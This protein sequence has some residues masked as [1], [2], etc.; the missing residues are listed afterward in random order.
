MISV[1][2]AHMRLQPRP[3]PDLNMLRVAHEQSRGEQRCVKSRSE[4]AQSGYFSRSS[5]IGVGIIADRIPYGPCIDI[6]H[7]R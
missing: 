7:I 4:N 3:S 2:L 1:V 5:T 6:L